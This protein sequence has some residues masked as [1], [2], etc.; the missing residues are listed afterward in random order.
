M[1]MFEWMVLCVVDVCLVVWSV[2]DLCVRVMW[3]G[4]GFEF[5]VLVWEMLMSDWDWCFEVMEVNMCVA[6]ER[7]WGWDATE[8]RR[9][10]NNGVVRFVLV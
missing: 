3:E 7:T 8:K 4:Y 1:G 10:L 2:R 9:E 6:Y 5:Y